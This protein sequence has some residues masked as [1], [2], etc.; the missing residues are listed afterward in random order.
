VFVHS[1]MNTDKSPKLVNREEIYKARTFALY[2]EFYRGENGEV[3]IEAIRHRGAVAVLPILPDGSIILEKQFRYTIS[4]W[5]IEAPAGTLEAGESDEQC[6]IRELAEETGLTAKELIRVGAIVMTPGY[7]DEVI[8][9]FVAHVDNTVKSTNLDKDELIN[10][11]KFNSRQ[12]TDMIK[13]GEIYDA[14]T[15]ALFFMSKEMKLI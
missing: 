2:K 15:I 13:K 5:I 8:R 3:L 10:T 14:K 6:A 12:I 1:A 11:V 7:D 4:K 9:L